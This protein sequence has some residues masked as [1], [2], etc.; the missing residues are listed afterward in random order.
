MSKEAKKN[1]LILCSSGT[2]TVDGSN[3]FASDF[4]KRVLAC[5]GLKV[6]IGKLAQQFALYSRGN[7][8]SDMEAPTRGPSSP[9]SHETLD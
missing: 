4:S 6:L 9:A 2:V 3:N 5:L 7:Q 8:I 1:D